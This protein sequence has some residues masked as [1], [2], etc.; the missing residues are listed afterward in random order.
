METMVA[1]VTIIA[2]SNSNEVT[3]VVAMTTHL[4]N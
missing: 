4:L 3:I 2:Y 1:I